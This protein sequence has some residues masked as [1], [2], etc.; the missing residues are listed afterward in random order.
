VLLVDGTAELV[1]NVLGSLSLWEAC[2]ENMLK[3]DSKNFIRQ[4]IPG[5]ALTP[6]L[7]YRESSILQKS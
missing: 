7:N 3:R 5:W 6:G 2:D 4:A 1:A